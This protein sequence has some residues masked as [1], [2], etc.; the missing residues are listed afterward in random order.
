MTSSSRLKGRF[1]ENG[2]DAGSLVELAAGVA[3]EDVE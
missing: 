2:E 1:A 3:R